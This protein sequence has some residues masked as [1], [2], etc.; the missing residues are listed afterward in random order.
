MDA[1]RALV[2]VALEA[3]A[4]TLAAEGLSPVYVAVDGRVEGVGGI[5]DPVRADARTT[6]DALRANG[7]RVLVLS[8]DHPDVVARVAV[9]LGIAPEDARGGLTPEAKRDFVARLMA[10]P[11]RRGSVVMVGDGVNDT[12][13]SPWPTSASPCSA[14]RAPRSSPPTW[15]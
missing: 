5:G 13:A 1:A 7:I 4:A 12:S 8:G 14:A 3:H 9:V 11:A 10:E 6:V 15:C 2:P